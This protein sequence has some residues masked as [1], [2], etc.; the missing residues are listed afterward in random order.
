MNNPSLKYI[1]I[2]VLASAAFTAVI[3]L[4]AANLTRFQ[5]VGPTIPFAYPWRLLQPTALASLTAW[6]LYLLHNLIVW[7]IIYLAQ[8]EQPKFTNNLRWFNWVL[9]ATNVSFII[10]HII[11]SQLWFDGLAANVPEITA[12]GSVAVMLMVIIIFETPRR[13]LIFGKNFKF[14]ESFMKIV[15]KYHGYFFAWA[16]IYTFWYHPAE[17]TWGHLLGFFYMFMLFAQSALIF[18]RAHINTWW[19]FFLEFFVLIHGTMVA[20]L[21]GNNMWPMFTFGFG[22][23][24]VLTQMYGLGLNTWTK[25]ALAIGF[26]IITVAT[27]TFMGRLDQWNEVIRIPVLDYMVIFLLYGIYLAINWALNLFKRPVT[28]QAGTD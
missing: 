7:T 14:K 2:G 24:L 22:A 16:T 3:G 11:Q 4:T 17:G 15:R 20:I 13:G 10:L 1:S 21:Q 19:T 5:I 28:L 27:Y 8:R 23:M 12:L 25:R 26:I 9:I 18:N 6:G